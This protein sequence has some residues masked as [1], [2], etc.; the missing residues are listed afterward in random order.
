MN[1]VLWPVLIQN[2]FRNHKP[3]RPLAELVSQE[4][5]LTRRLDVY[6]KHNF[7]III[8]IIRLFIL[9]ENGYLPGGSGTTIGHNTQITQRS[10]ETQHTKL[11]TQ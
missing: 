1:S 6:F 7:I 10:N 9:T 8:I 11:H 2:F 4:S 3:C 5:S